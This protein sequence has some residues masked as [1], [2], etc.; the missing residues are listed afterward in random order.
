MSNQNFSL[1][2]KLQNAISHH[3][4]AGFSLIELLVSI[5]LLG[6]LGGIGVSIFAVIN[7]SYDSANALSRMQT[8]GS[9]VLEVLERSI[10]GST[11]IEERGNGGGCANDRCLIITIP[12]NSIE[13]SIN[14]GCAKTVYGWTAETGSTNGQ[15]VRYYLTDTNSQCNGSVPIQLFDTDPR[16]GVSVQQ[17]DGSTNI[18]TTNT[19]AE[20]ISSV[21]INM[22]LSE[23]VNISN[24]ITIPLRTTVSLRYY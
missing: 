18:F 23:G 11:N 1:N 2:P 6:I 24:P 8:Q 7:N 5:A 9:Q 17:K 12:S 20:G 15:L 3:Q 22:V 19:G 13:Y 4:A 10:R 16:A 14:G 21:T